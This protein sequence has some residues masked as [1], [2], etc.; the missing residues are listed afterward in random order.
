LFIKVTGSNLHTITVLRYNEIKQAKKGKIIIF[1]T[2][3]YLASGNAIQRRA[4]KVINELNII[5]DM[6]KYKPVL[7]GTIP[8]SI[9]I[10]GSDL[11]I[12]MEVHDFGLF[13]DDVKFLYGNLNGFVFTEMT[14]KGTPTITTNFHFGGFEFEL[15]GQP[16]VVEQQNAYRHMIVEHHLLITNP[17]IKTEII[18]LKEQGI[19]TEPTFA[20]VFGLVGDPY[21]ELLIFGRKLG[22]IN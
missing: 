5:N 1:K 22:V 4:F 12:V 20:Q 11:D 9:D 16:R 3:T 15:F 14:V 17:H 6:A 19:K 10:K 18:R 7:C 8:I 13:K 2:I 21:D